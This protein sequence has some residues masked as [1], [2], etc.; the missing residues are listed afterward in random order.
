MQ[1]EIINML[2]KS[3]HSPIVLSS[4]AGAELFLPPITHNPWAKTGTLYVEVNGFSTGTAS[5]TMDV[6]LK[7][8]SSYSQYVWFDHYSVGALSTAFSSSIALSNLGQY[9]RLSITPTVDSVY[10][11]VMLELNEDRPVAPGFAVKTTPT[12]T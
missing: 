9:V 2:A 7:L 10:A 12:G 8:Y 3:T 1:K 5:P 11:R 6:A 4:A